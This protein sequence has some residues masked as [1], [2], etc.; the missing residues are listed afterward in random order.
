MN[1]STHL[2]NDEAE[3]LHEVYA[4]QPATLLIALNRTDEMYAAEVVKSYER[5]A[6]YIASRLQGLGY[7]NFVI[8]P[9]SALTG[10]YADQVREQVKVKR[11]KLTRGLQ[12]AAQ[13]DNEDAAAYLEAKVKEMR[14]FQGMDM[15]S[16][17]EVTAMSRMKYL[18][19]LIR[20]MC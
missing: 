17:R 6:D 2:S 13:G 14:R 3:L 16:M 5:A 10:M 11:G 9:I 4:S 18:M 19:H 7:D 8:V 12:A 1:Y 15:R 20:H